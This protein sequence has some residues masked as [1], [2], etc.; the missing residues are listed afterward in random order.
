MKINWPSK[1]VDDAKILLTNIINDEGSFENICVDQYGA[2]KTYV[3]NKD[4]LNKFAAMSLIST[5]YNEDVAK[6]LIAKAVN[7]N[8]DKIVDWLIKSDSVLKVKV[9]TQEPIGIQINNRK[10]T[11][12][13]NAIVTLRRDVDNSTE[14]GF[15]VSG[16]IPTIS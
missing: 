15:Y 8:F 13:C 11:P 4:K 6:S 5:C 3:I 2:A 1:T 12:C 14:Y 16:V 9:H 7:N 10:E